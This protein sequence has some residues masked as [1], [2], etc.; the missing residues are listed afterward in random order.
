MLTNEAF[1]ALLKTL[2]EPPAYAVFI[3]ATTDPHKVPITILSRCQRYDF[4]RIPT[5]MIQ[6]HLARLAEEEGWKID[7]EGLALVARAAEGGLRDA[8]GFLDQVVTFGGDGVSV[9]EIARIL[10]VTDRGSLLG[11]LTAIIDRHGPDLLGLIETLYNQGQDLGRFYQDLILYARHLLVAGLHPEARHLAAVADTEWDALIA[12]ARRTP[13][14]HLHNLL[15]V[16]LQG[17]EDLKRA[18]QPRLALEVLL[19][20]VIHLEPVL[21]LTD[22]LA[23][24]DSLE[25]RLEAGPGVGGASAGAGERLVRQVVATVEEPAVTPAR[26]V[27]AV[28]GVGLDASLDEQWQAFLQFVQEKE[29]GP[30]YGKLA[31]C[32][33]MG[34]SDNCLKIA[35]G[36][37]WNANGARHEARVQELART[38]FGPETT[39]EFE[40]EAP[41]TPKKTPAAAK[42]PLDMQKLQ[43]Q[44]LEIFGGEWISATP[45]KEEPE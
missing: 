10:G 4:R 42:K 28:P 17:E 23:R 6:A 12:L 5:G 41:K 44:A 30:L 35:M 32:R 24:L 22:W 43:Q 39:L 45:G 36:R 19:L 15:S 33:L 20:R 14:V 31:Q 34:R 25:K 18:P 38:F 27:A 9:A 7:S 37:P 8:Q 26:P 11:A 2:E 29:N 21:P 1:N 3:L 40:V 13:A 16:L